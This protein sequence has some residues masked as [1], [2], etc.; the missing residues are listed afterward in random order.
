MLRNEIAIQDT[1][2][3][4][5][6]FKSSGDWE[7]QFQS[8]SE[9]LGIFPDLEQNMLRSAEDLFQTVTK[10]FE[11]GEQ[12]NRLYT[13]ASLKYYEDTTNQDAKRLL[14]K[15]Q[16]LLTTYSSATAFFDTTLP[17]LQ[18]EILETFLKDHK[19]LQAYEILLRDL[20]RYQP[21][22]LSKSEE[23]LLALFQKERE[24]ASDVYQ[25]FTDSDLKFGN[26]LDEDGNAV[27]LTDTNYMLYLQSGNREVRKS[28]FQ[29]LYASYQQYQNT[30][31]AL[32][33]G[34]IETE[35][36]LA[37]ARNFESALAMSLFADSVTPEIYQ[38]IIENISGH[39]DVLFQYYQLK[40][41]VLKLDELHI[42]DI[43]LPLMKEV[44]QKYSYEQA[45]QQ[46]LSA[47]E[48]FGE[49]YVKIL[50]KG[51]AER[52]VDV[53]PNQGKTG[54]AF[55]GGCATT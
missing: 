1:W 24:T 30:F 53:Y 29:T 38:N 7:Q 3:L 10:I 39:L 26:I 42:Y 44:S 48:I 15:A 20:Y 43:Y 2:D 25:T 21:H 54:G 14:G 45:V 40:K 23:K 31:A 6:I 37:K 13:Y 9:K 32:Y 18:P 8:V 17:E 27:E 22:T 55:S 34:Q 50:R 5:R 12:V 35:K 52:W 36:T 28:A 41:K 51:Y 4:S 49:D 47:M 46:V 19:G 11:I 16:N 33:A